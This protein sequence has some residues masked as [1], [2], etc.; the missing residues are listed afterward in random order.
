MNAFIYFSRLRTS[1]YSSDIFLYS[2][3]NFCFHS[4]FS[5]SLSGGVV[6]G[7]F[8]SSIETFLLVSVICFQRFHHFANLL[9]VFLQAKSRDG[10][11]SRSLI[12][13]R[14]F[15]C[16]ASAFS[17][18]ISNLVKSEL[19]FRSA[20]LTAFATGFSLIILT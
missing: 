4:V 7:A 14:Y 15:S 20:S 5:F 2:S 13:F 17:S 3:S 6:F 12:A 9:F 1:R 16:L 8:F 19:C 18:T 11:S 10:Y